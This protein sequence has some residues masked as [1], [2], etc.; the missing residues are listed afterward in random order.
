M[1]TKAKI[2]KWNLVYFKRF[3]IAKETMNKKKKDICKLYDQKGVN[4]HILTAHI[5]QYKK[6]QTT[7]LKM[8]RAHFSKEEMQTANRHTKKCSTSL[9]IR[10]MQ[11]KTTMR[12]HH[13]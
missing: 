9:I 1:E 4:I 12:Y 13:T 5:A 10:E 3:C 2:N 6:N 7:Q 8:G 11:V